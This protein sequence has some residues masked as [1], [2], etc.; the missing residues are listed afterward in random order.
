MSGDGF[1]WADTTFR[2]PTFGA[3]SA[4]AWFILSAIISASQIVGLFGITR[5]H[6][7]RSLP[8]PTLTLFWN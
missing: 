6:R 3:A 4:A 7:P 1:A 2:P 8:L 5:A